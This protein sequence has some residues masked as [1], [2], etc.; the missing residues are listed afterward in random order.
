MALT[1]NLKAKDRL[2]PSQETHTSF[3]TNKKKIYLPEVLLGCLWT[4]LAISSHFSDFY[5][6]S[7]FP[8]IRR[9]KDG[10]FLI[11]IES[12][13]SVLNT[14]FAIKWLLIAFYI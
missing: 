1:T 8:T 10:G 14:I 12:T 2:G 7:P 13:S 4:S 5:K 3:E 11:L 9:D 6:I